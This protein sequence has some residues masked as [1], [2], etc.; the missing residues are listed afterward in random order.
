[1]KV[2]AGNWFRRL[3]ARAC[4]HLRRP[5]IPG[6]LRQGGTGGAQVRLELTAEVMGD[7]SRELERTRPP[8][9][10]REA[11]LQNLRLRACGSCVLRTGCLER[12]RLSVKL[13]D[14]PRPFPCRKPGRLGRELRE[15][16][17]SLRRM[18]ALRR[19]EGE[20]R[21]A[22]ASQYRFLEIYLRR[23]SDRLPRGTAGRRIRYSI[24]AAVRTR[25]RDSVSGDR[26]AAFPGDAGRYYFLLC[27]GMGV[28]P[29]AREDSRRFLA[30][31][32]QLLLS[33]C[34][35]REALRSL[36]S[37]LTLGNRTGAVTVDLAELRLDNGL[38]M[39]YKWGAAPG[40]LVRRGRTQKIG[41]AMPPPGLSVTEGREWTA[42]LSLRGGETLIL[43][44]DGV[45]GEAVPRRVGLA[46]DAPPGEM[47]ERLLELSSGKPEDDATAAVIRLYPGSSGSS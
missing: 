40:Y 31:L 37:F 45:D 29:A 5:R 15:A 27:D 36:N 39:L 2:M 23:L 12:K 19:R 1:M 3:W 17:Q 18:E 30:L 28:G 33:G 20:Y 41:T 26:W 21:A 25:R 7:F 14:D 6:G 47:A 8:E 44:S 16:R 46:P 10:D 13:L 32:R 9:I 11:L 22:L 43:V 24:R 42:R 35:P 38:A 34:P 4:R